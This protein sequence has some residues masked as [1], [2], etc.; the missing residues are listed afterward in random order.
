MKPKPF[1]SGRR[2]L[3]WMGVH[4]ADDDP[5]PVSD[6]RK[7]AKKVFAFVYATLFIGTSIF[8]VTSL[9]FQF[10]NVEE[11]FFILVQF[12]MTVQGSTSFIMIYLHGSRLSTLYQSLTS[13]Y[14]KC[15]IIVQ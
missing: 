12:I 13:I 10:V 6:Q 5:V 3:T 14:E 1:E 15:Q 11:F 8:H 4:F 7:F 9:E 2:A